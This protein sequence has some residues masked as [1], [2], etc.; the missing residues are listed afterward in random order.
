MQHLI[1]NQ[2]AGSPIILLYHRSKPVQTDVLKYSIV[3]TA[4]EVSANMEKEEHVQWMTHAKAHSYY[5][6]KKVIGGAK[7]FVSQKDY[8]LL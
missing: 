4:K 6:R 1:D 8:Q 3:V 7:F 5:R 2:N